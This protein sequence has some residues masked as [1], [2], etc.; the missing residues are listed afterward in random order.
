MSLVSSILA[1]IFKPSTD[2]HDTQCFS[3]TNDPKKF[4]G[5][6]K[7]QGAALHYHS[8]FSN[9]AIDCPLL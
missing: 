2:M 7:P 1:I 4:A 5:R 8:S 3:P 9:T 6:P